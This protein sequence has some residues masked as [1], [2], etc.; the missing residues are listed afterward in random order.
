MTDWPAELRKHAA[1]LKNASAAFKAFQGEDC[2]E[3]CEALDDA[4]AQFLVDATE[5]ETIHTP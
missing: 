3:H 1:N 4:A 2:V 5:Y